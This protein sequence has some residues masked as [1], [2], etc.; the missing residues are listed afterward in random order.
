M[1]R[2]SNSRF[3]DVTMNTLSKF[4]ATACTPRLPKLSPRRKSVLRG[5][6]A[7]MSVS[8]CGL[9]AISTQSPTVG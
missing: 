1:R 7:V 8:P 3:S 6:S 9:G 2:G 4:A 5:L